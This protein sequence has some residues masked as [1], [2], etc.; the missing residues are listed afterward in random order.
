MITIKEVK[1]R[2]Q[3]AEF[4]DF[5]TKLYNNNKYYVH[6]LRIDEIN[7]FNR[8]K[9]VY[10]EDCDAVFY[11][12]YKDDK[13]VGRIAGILQRL[14]NDKTKEKRVRFTRFDSTNDEEVATALFNAVENWAKQKGMN[15]VHGPLGFNDLDREGLLIEGFDYIATFE[16][17]YNYNY[18]QKLIEKCGY[19]KEIDW[20]EYRIYPPKEISERVQRLSD[21]VLKRYNLKVVNEKNKNEYL[22]KYKKGIFEVLDEAY[23]S[24]YGVVPFNDRLRDQIV[25]QFKLFI[26]LRYVI[27]IVDENDE[28]VA[29]GFAIPS[30]S[31]AVQKSKGRFFPFGFI[32]MLKAI[33][34]T[35][36]A[37]LGLIAV[38]T[39]YQSKGLLAVV[40]NYV[41]NNMIKHN[42]E[43][44]E[45][46]LML[47]D[48]LRIQQTWNNFEH[49]QHK[50]RRSFIKNLDK[51]AE[52]KNEN[53]VLTKSAK[54][55]ATIAKKT[56]V[57]KTEKTS[58][59]KPIKKTENKAVK[60]TTKKTTIK[61]PIK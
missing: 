22:K 27:T 2:K 60:A 59:Q 16:E 28:V 46:N 18:Y 57:R 15:K 23:S 19:Q 8:K 1:T 58:E 21:T 51:L 25:S 61:K 47:E 49:I 33:N 48:N 24:L 40:L 3:Q 12:A 41:I 17:Q 7:L 9:N 20:L 43:Y 34:E 53:T 36:Y 5:P 32:R 38:K 6:P 52:N 14:Y 10:Y 13:I 42:L 29:F 56:Q 31:E 44:C 39:E 54:K 4:V 26:K 50:R 45:T 37:D 30:L 11:L 55:P 35:K